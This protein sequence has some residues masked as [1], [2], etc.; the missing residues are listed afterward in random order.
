MEFNPSKCQVIH[1][2]R[3]KHPI[4]SKYKL[5][6]VLLESVTSAKYLG[7]DISNNLS[8]DT[9]IKRSTKK[10]NQ[11]LGFLRRNLQVK[12]EPLKSMAYQT[13][14]RP[15]LEYGSEI[16]SPHTQ[17]LIDQIE[18]V[19]RRAARWIKA[20]FY[21]TSSVT[22]MLHS[23][24]LRRLDQRRIDNRLS[25]M[26][27]IHNDLVAIPVENYLVPLSRPARHCHSLSYRLITATTDYYK[28]S[29][30]PRTIYHWNHLP[31]DI[32]HLPTI[33][34]FNTAVCHIDHASP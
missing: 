18:G 8:W 21:R 16:W 13:L 27:K 34:Q 6:G 4:P 17:T 32:V 23:L 1:V 30:F 10:A 9:H 15:Q 24:N 3:R 28:F 19:Q 22:D 11:T 26:Y 12:S 2:T 25:L 20:D 33:E 7:V 31:P 14:V 29:F 5:H